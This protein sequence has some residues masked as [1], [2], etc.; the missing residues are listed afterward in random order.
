MICEYLKT[1][2]FSRDT[3]ILSQ[4][5][6]TSNIFGHSATTTGGL[7][8]SLNYPILNLKKMA[9]PKTSGCSTAMHIEED[10]GPRLHLRWSIYL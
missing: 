5:H 7:G 1:K 6:G 4:M 10:L 3:N 8:V 9:C 2:I